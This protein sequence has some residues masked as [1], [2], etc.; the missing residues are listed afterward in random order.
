MQKKQILKNAAILVVWFLLWEMLTLA[1]HSRLIMAGPME[2]AAAFVRLVTTTDFYKCMGYSV[3]RVLLGFLTALFGALL[4][5]AASYKYPTL[6]AFF[7]PMLLFMRSIPVASFV[8]IAL[9]WMGSKN[10]SVLIVVFVA[11]PVLY[12]QIMSGFQNADNKYR[13]LAAVFEF[14]LWTKIC[15]IYAPA[16]KEG[17]LSACRLAVGMSFKAGIAAEVI[18]GSRGSI[19]EQLYL[20]KLYF[21]TGELF[22]WTV[23][24]VGLSFVCEQL[25]GWMF[26]R[27][28]KWMMSGKVS[29]S[30][31]IFSDK[32]KRI[33]DAGSVHEN[34]DAFSNNG[35][36]KRDLTHASS[37]TISMEHVC[38]SFGEQTVLSDLS[39]NVCASEILGVTGAS[40]IGKTTFLGLICGFLKPDS[41]VVDAPGRTAVL[42]QDSR[43]IEHQDAVTNAA[44]GLCG[45]HGGCSKAQAL[46]MAEAALKEILPEHVLH[47]PVSSLSGGQRRRVELVRTMLAQASVVVLDEPFA[48][49][50]E[51]TKKICQTFIRDHRQERLLVIAVHEREALEELSVT[52]WIE[53]DEYAD[54]YKNSCN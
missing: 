50:D 32:G 45:R 20:A 16:M 47:Q 4:L 26:N 43:L 7:A 23:V 46:H 38:K 11:L 49:L 10:L 29:L 17:F 42:F 41:G 52:H 54:V 14:P 51:E 1:I 18:A 6:G 40:G 25:T 12:S 48:G 3:C 36:L 19:G 30:G 27:G 9:L 39:V 8:I 2:T 15:A 34:P 44:Y 5:A 13:E 53:L 22:A 33:S 37:G 21:S 28:L 24:I 31:A 35:D